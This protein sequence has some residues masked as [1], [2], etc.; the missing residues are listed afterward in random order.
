MSWDPRR[1]IRDDLRAAIA[2]RDAVRVSVLR[3]TLAALANAEA[4]DAPTVPPGATE[5]AR[6]E[7]DAAAIRSVIEGEHAEAMDAAAL[8]DRFGRRAE[9][10]QLRRQAGEILRYLPAAG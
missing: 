10:A 5:V 7:L 8:L 1:Q 2:Q 3:T 6:R 9:A 4:V